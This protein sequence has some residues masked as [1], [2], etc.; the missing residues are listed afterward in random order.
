MPPGERIAKGYEAA[1]R[2]IIGA[3]GRRPVVAA[4][5][6]MPGQDWESIAERLVAAIEAE[7]RS[8]GSQGGRHNHLTPSPQQQPTVSVFFASDALRSPNEL[9]ALFAPYL[10]GGPVFG[11]VCDRELSECFDDSKCTALAD[12]VHATRADIALLIGPGALLPQFRALAGT[13]FY[14]D[15]T[16]EALGARRHASAASAAADPAVAADTAEWYRRSFYVDW[17]VHE[18]HKRNVIG[19]ADYYIDATREEPRVVSRTLLERLLAGTAGQPFRCKPYFQPGVWGGQRLKQAAGL[20]DS[21][22]N[23][24]WDFELVAP[25]NSILLSFEGE[26]DHID[27]P[28]HLIMWAGARAILGRQGHRDFGDFF[29]VRINYLDTMGGGD[30]STQVHPQDLYIRE[31]FGESIGQH[32]SYYVVET[33]PGAKVHVGLRNG[34]TRDAFAAAI[35]AAETDAVPFHRDDF[36]NAWDAR[37]GDYFMIPAGTVHCSGRGNLVLEISSTPYWYTFKLYDYLRPDLNGRPRPINSA[38]GLAVLDLSRDER[39]ARAHLL[40]EPALVRSGPGGDEYLIGTNYLVFYAVNR[41]HVRSEIVEGT[42]DSPHILV[43]TAGRQVWV[44]GGDTDRRVRIDYLEALV[45]PASFG[46]YRIVNE[47]G[48]EAQVLKVY[49]K[50]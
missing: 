18:R 36:V 25:E 23:S 11:R 28:F 35:H 15:T 2:L 21:M 14:C 47:T 39:W 27:V 8:Q 17:P 19:V 31:H 1:A 33:A 16:R 9:E 43:L 29:P 3:A 41:L 12:E 40:A 5:D 34:V 6:G 7:Q 46:A 20:P 22:A 13:S 38:H 44:I 42:H 24:A 50:G 26:A 32:E 48:G 30:L 49:L 4:V 45:V 10:A 37:A